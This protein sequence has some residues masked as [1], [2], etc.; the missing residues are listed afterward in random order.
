MDSMR[1]SSYWAGWPSISILPSTMPT[2]PEFS[3]Q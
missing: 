3:D 1:Q 2:A